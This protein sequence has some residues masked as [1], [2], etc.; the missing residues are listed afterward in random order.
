MW[1]FPSYYSQ[2]SLNISSYRTVAALPI[3]GVTC[4]FSI[5]GYSRT[6]GIV[7]FAS[8]V[9][10]DLSV[11]GLTMWKAIELCER[12]SPSLKYVVQ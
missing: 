1:Y 9:I 12:L 2:N 11:S 4:S 8:T 5:S 7:Q 3:K 10:F 6:A